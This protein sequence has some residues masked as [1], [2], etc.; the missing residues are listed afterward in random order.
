MSESINNEN[1]DFSAKLSE[2]DKIFIPKDLDGNVSIEQ[3]AEYEHYLVKFWRI[4][5][6][7]FRLVKVNRITQKI[8]SEEGF[9]LKFAWPIFTKTILVPSEI[10]DGKKEYKNEVCLSK[11]KIEISV[12]L[13]LVMNITD[14]VKYKRKGATQL[15]QLNPLVKE[16]LRIYVAIKKFDELVTEECNLHQFDPTGI[17]MNYERECGVRIS[18]VI[19]EKVQLPERLKKLYNDAAEEEQRRKAQAIKLQA[20]QERAEAEAKIISIQAKAE[21][22]K[23]ALIEGAKVDAYIKKMNEFVGTLQAKGIPVS[24][25]AEQL[26]L[27]IASKNGNTIFMGGK[28]NGNDIAT[29]IYAGKVAF[30]NRKET[31]RKTNPNTNEVYSNSERLVEQI[32]ILEILLGKLPEAYEDL[33]EALSIPGNH[34]KE[35]VDKLTEEKYQELVRALHSQLNNRSKTEENPPKGLKR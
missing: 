33:K 2:M 23:I 13:A 12:D 7:N 3:L 31:K 5:P 19:L 1:I 34:K 4:V 17:L 11:D 28:N 16:L 22:G 30:E 20:E 6:E 9:G 35:S 15:K 21:A 25:I 29:G 14:P 8:S 26:K 18:K 27:E 32:T 24:E 10:L